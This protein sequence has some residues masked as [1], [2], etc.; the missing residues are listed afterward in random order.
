[1]DQISVNFAMGHSDSSMAAIYRQGI[2][3]SRL[4]NVAM[5]VHKWLFS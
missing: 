2:D 3:D 5:H 1:M 4:V